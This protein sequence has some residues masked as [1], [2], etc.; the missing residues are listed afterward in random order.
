MPGKMIQCLKKTKTENPLVLIDEVD[1]IGKGYQ[2]DPASALL[3]LLDPEQ[4]K[5]FLDHYLDVPVDLSKVTLIERLQTAIRH[6]CFIHSLPRII[7]NVWYARS[8]LFRSIHFLGRK[9]AFNG[10]DCTEYPFFAQLDASQVLH[11]RSRINGLFL[12]TV[13]PGQ[14]F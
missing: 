1:K 4:N 5:N 8:P 6:V 11:L 3:E 10:G 14:L 7:G 2:G 9:H 13:F 12:S